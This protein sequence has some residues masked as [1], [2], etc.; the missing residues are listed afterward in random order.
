MC[1][2]TEFEFMHSQSGSIFSAH[3]HIV[4][5]LQCMAVQDVANLHVK[6]QN[7]SDFR[8]RAQ[9]RSLI[10]LQM[11]IMM[12]LK[13]PCDEDKDSGCPHLTCEGWNVCLLA[14]V[15][16]IESPVIES[17]S[18]F[19]LVGKRHPIFKSPPAPR[20][21]FIEVLTL[22]KR[23]EGEKY[24]PAA[25]SHSVFNSFIVCLRDEGISL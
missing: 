18:L 10:E 8:T 25:C 13:S 23:C 24:C 6:Q 21:F 22:Q 20:S 19:A 3:M 4:A 2:Q 9:D 5:V 16:I 14:S 7:K 12:T 1:R 17:P 11:Q 15:A